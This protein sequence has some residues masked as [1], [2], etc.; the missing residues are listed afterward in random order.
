MISWLA[1]QHHLTYTSPIHLF[2]ATAMLCGDKKIRV[3][4]GEI[5][6]DSV[7]RNQLDANDFGKILGRLQ[8][9]EF[10]P[11]KRFTDL[12]QD[13][14]LNIST[15]HN[16]ALEKT[17]ANLLARLPPIPI[18]NTKQ[19]LTL[20]RELLASNES[21]IKNE[22]LLVLLVLWEDSPSLRKVLKSLGGFID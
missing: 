4:A 5:W 21:T 15:L 7:I 11:L 19:L 1:A 9:K 14:L 8:N 3:K 22:R 16:V 10:A 18:K 6:Q 2:L 17:I 13:Q 12:A 20:Y